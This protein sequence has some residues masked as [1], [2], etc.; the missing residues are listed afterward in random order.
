MPSG[1]ASVPEAQATKSV[2]TEKEG[3]L[4]AFEFVIH[5]DVTALKGTVP[6]QWVEDFKQVHS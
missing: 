4:E 5:L 2:H 1:A 6:N 3:D